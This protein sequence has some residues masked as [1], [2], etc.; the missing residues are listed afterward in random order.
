[1]P[2]LN[3]PK[4]GEL[5]NTT[6][7]TPSSLISTII[8]PASNVLTTDGQGGMYFVAGITMP[9]MYSTVQGLGSGGYVSSPQLL[10][11]IADLG[12]AG[13]ISSTQL[14]S[15]I[16]DL[17]Q[18][19]YVS[20]TQLN[21]T[22]FGLG[23]AGYIST[24]AIEG[25]FIS[26]TI[27]LAQANY[28][29]ST[30][31]F[32]AM[33]YIY[34]TYVST[35]QLVSTVANLGTA[36]YV[37]TSQ[38]VSTTQ[39]FLDN[40][41]STGQLRSTVADLGHAGYVS[42]AQLLST[43]TGL[44]SAT[45]VSSPS[46]VSTTVYFLT[47][48]VSTGQLKSTIADLAQANYVSSTQL[49]STVTGLANAN[50]VSSTQLQSTV[51][52]LANAN[53]VSSTQLQSTVAGLGSAT[54]V[55][56]PS[57]VSTT[58]YFLDNYVSTG[59]LRSTV[60]N[61]G[62]ASY[63]SSTQLLSTVTG[64][65]SLNYVSA[66][67][68]AS[69]VDYIIANYVSTG[70]LVSTVRQLGSLG[71]VSSQQIISTTASFL[72][73][74][75]TQTLLAGGVSTA[76]L[77]T[78]SIYASNISAG[79]LVIYGSNT[80][81]VE[82]NSVMSSI[83]VV[84]NVNVSSINGFE[85]FVKSSGVSTSQVLTS[86]LHFR[87]VLNPASQSRVYLTGGTLVLDGDSIITNSYLGLNFVSTTNGLAQASYVSSS[88][89]RSTVSG[90]GNANYVSST[91]LQSTVAGLSQT[92]FVSTTQLQST[93]AGL[94][95]ANYVSSTQLQSTVANLAN[96]NYVSSTQLQSTVTGL[97]NANYVSSTQ[98]QSTV[99]GLAFSTYVSSTQL[100]STVAG[101]ANANYVSSTQLQSTVAGLANANYVSST[102]L[103][104]TVA[105]LGSAS[106][107]S[108]PHLLSTYTGIQQGLITS[109]LVV[110]QSVRAASTYTRFLSTTTLEGR[111]IASVQ[112]YG[113]QVLNIARSTDALDWSNPVTNGFLTGGQDV[114][115]GPNIYVAAGDGSNQ[116]GSL[117]WSVTGLSWSDAAFGG[118]DD[119][120][121]HYR[122]YAVAYNGT[123]RYVA[124]GL[125]YNGRTAIVTSTDGKNWLA[126]S[127]GHANPVY[128]VLWA[129]NLGPGGTGLWIAVGDGQGV[130]ARSIQYSVD[131]FTWNA[132]P[133]GF[134]NSDD[135][136]I[137][138][139]LA[140]D[141]VGKLWAVGYGDLHKNMM[142]SANGSNWAVKTSG[143]VFT[144]DYAYGVA[145]NPSPAVGAAKWVA[146]G[147]GANQTR[148]SILYSGDGNTWSLVPAGNG[149]AGLQGNCVIWDSY[150][151][152]WLAGGKGTEFGG[153]FLQSTD[154]ISWASMAGV[155]FEYFGTYSANAVINSN[156]YIAVG[157]G[158]TQV[159]GTQATLIGPSS[160]STTHI[161]VATL[162]ADSI[163]VS[164]ANTLT[165]EGNSFFNGDATFST[166]V[167]MT[168]ATMSGNL[169]VTSN[170]TIQGDI[171]LQSSD[172]AI[173]TTD[174][175]TQNIETSTL[176]F[177]DIINSASIATAFVS[178]SLL[179]VNGNQVLTGGA[180]GGMLTLRNLSVI[181]TVTS[182]STFTNFVSTATL[183]TRFISTLG[184][185]TSTITFRDIQFPWVTHRLYASSSML[186][187]NTINLTSSI[188]G[189]ACGECANSNTGF[190]NVLIQGTLSTSSTFVNY[191]STANI[192]TQNMTMS[193]LS[194]T[195]MSASSISLFDPGS[196]QS[197]PL[198]ANNGNLY[199]GVSS[200]GIIPNV[201]NSN[202]V[203][204]TLRVLDTISTDKMYVNYLSSVQVTVSTANLIDGNNGQ[205]YPLFVSGGILK[206]SDSVIL[207]FGP[208]LNLN[209][210]STNST[211]AQSISTNFADIQK[212]SSL[213]ATV[214]TIRFGDQSSNVSNF[215]YSRGNVLQ[216]N[217]SAVAFGGTLGTAPQ[218]S[219]LRVAQTIS[220]SS[221]FVNYLS[222]GQILAS[223]INAQGAILR[224]LSAATLAASSITMTDGSGRFNFY[225]NSSNLFYN[226][227]PV[228]LGGRSSLNPWFSS[229][230]VSTTISTNSVVAN[231]LSTNSLQTYQL[232]GASSIGFTDLVTQ[233]VNNIYTQNGTLY[234]NENPATGTIVVAS[235]FTLSNLEV[236][237][238]TSTASTFVNYVSAG[239]QL[240]DTLSTTFTSAY[241]IITSSFTASNVTATTGT[242]NDL[243]VTNVNSRIYPI[244]NWGTATT[245]CCGSYAGFA[246]VGFTNTYSSPPAVTVTLNDIQNELAIMNIT[247]VDTL[248]FT[249]GSYDIN[250]GTG[251]LLS[252]ISFMWMAVGT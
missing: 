157:S 100:Q 79:T 176:K 213:E 123:N 38:L 151:N 150:Q 221:T 9:V 74:F 24:T 15:S 154:G 236:L 40:Y 11:T 141:G 18:A 155:P 47:N 119:L 204:Q 57:L 105:N 108:S 217:G 182:A 112:V 58:Q 218:F 114:V 214:S 115:A 48:Y 144:G 142:Y 107:I 97:A 178:S 98:L 104:S 84:G 70:Q 127:N 63:I 193:V 158:E 143:D 171:I 205:S 88:Q 118:F 170:V 44:G 242:V 33:Q 145:V 6:F 34:N 110:Q 19:S 243:Q 222:T 10:S 117:K 65:G 29:S 191:I 61:L 195:T 42:S 187:F 80:L 2:A 128:G 177:V 1:M 199:F 67:Q 241:D 5:Y 147:V 211:F 23:T 173:T 113:N 198:T 36:R 230:T 161:D 82:G 159:A 181:N 131:G 64:L 20:S 91:Q 250:S 239:F 238:T 50:Y 208:N 160:I 59:Q 224:S 179:Y 248:G 89:L 206:F 194:T 235:N 54:F 234:I 81:I 60:A 232:I 85:G 247:Y 220:S 149:F 130:S 225:G 77:S 49:Q 26:T 37:S 21:S 186:Y 137:G 73:R 148:E 153:T 124:G 116:I 94:A 32:S 163:I 86:T 106:Y 134:S 22:V 69:T 72:N 122:G 152:R 244:F 120:N 51:T 229:L 78:G 133:V 121:G 41:V 226:S 190:S 184:L 66:P 166:S 245:Q 251:L 185:T 125:G 132:V 202:L 87:D 103:Q 192:Q 164:G 162:T 13:Y 45:Y 139:N 7:F 146:V 31:H 101:L 43:V 136:C 71:Y 30:Q 53:Y 209:I 201:V 219:T 3:Q 8:I 196:G 140:Y 252:S 4:L 168:S 62:T 68:L 172:G 249:V 215:L 16:R 95:N 228:A 46:L 109:S 17:A 223:S 212:L 174:L 227:L 92:N 167:S 197:F 83:T 200:I 207:P 25:Y 129:P 237:N 203:L 52:G 156:Y 138:Y 76:S 96:A 12:S 99:A 231:L 56:S 165:V 189:N 180:T 210:L 14:L 28:V 175:T 39:Y 246:D 183:N 233:A 135:Q 169:T 55:S 240:I 188:V 90:L 75:T 102:Q 93:V 216:Y 111:K 126:A 35:G 27:G